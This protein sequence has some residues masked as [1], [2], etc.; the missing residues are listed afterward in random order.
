MRYFFNEAGG[1]SLRDD[2]GFDLPD[3]NAARIMAVKYAGELLRDHPTLIW[4]GQDFR[5]EVTG[6]DGLLLFTIVIVGVD[7]PAVQDAS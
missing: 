4:S 3:H 7:A 1:L 2:V 5:V 6:E